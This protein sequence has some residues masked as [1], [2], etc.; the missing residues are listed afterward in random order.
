MT[1][2]LQMLADQF[3]EL[4]PVHIN[5][6]WVEIDSISDLSIAEKHFHTIIQNEKSL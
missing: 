1:D 5:R 4:T 6:G 2:L 3:I